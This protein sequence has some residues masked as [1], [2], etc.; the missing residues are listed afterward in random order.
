M[1]VII[2]ATFFRFISPI[3]IFSHF[4]LL[5]S[6]LFDASRPRRQL[7]SLDTKQIINA[8]YN[9]LHTYDTDDL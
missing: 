9:L 3:Y 2:L 8:N 6:S 5:Y 7:I 1:F 4:F